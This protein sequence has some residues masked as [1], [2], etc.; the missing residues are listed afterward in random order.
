MHKPVLL[1]EVIATLDPQTGK[2]FVDCTVNRGGHA[3]AIAKRLDKRGVLVGIDADAN[4]LAE[5][6][7]NL[8]N[9]GPSVKLIH[10][11]FRHLTK[12][13]AELNLKKIDGTLFD[14]GLSSDQ[15]D[16]SGRGFTFQKD[17]PLV[18][19]F[20]TNP[21]DLPFTAGDILNEWTEEHLA[22]ILYGY[23]EERYSRQIA[24]A[25]VLA[26][27]KHPIET[28]GGLVAIIRGA[29][30]ITYTHRRLHFS[31]KTFQALRMAVNDELGAL[32][33]GLNAAWEHLNTGGRLGVISFHSL[34]ARVVKE[35]FKAKKK[36]GAGEWL[37]NKVIKPSREEML[38]NPRSRSAQLRAI[39][40]ITN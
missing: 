15:L 27:Q 37:T 20:D 21:I 19:S 1:K 9:I 24:K 31:T 40:K 30:P 32:K 18:M 14:L 36:D 6:R 10:G 34:E 2:I 25:I 29:V 22:D 13:L 33:E 38:A 16:G 7:R 39:K 35:F 8:Q 28:T 17:E 23:G 26:R 4:A 11:N 5:A 12:I 3:V